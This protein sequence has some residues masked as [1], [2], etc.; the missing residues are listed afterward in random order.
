MASTRQTGDPAK[1]IKQLKT[2]IK[3]LQGAACGEAQES[4]QR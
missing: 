1:L 4:D 2:L 3:V